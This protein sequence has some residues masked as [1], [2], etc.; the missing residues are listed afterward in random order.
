MLE[1]L[2][3]RRLHVPTDIDLRN[4]MHLELEFFGFN[5][6]ESVLDRNYLNKRQKK[7]E[8]KVQQEN[9]RSPMKSAL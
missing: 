8:V 7:M 4:L 2:K 5:D 3:S 1:H 9:Q 6:D